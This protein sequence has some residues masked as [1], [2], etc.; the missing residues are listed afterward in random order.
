MTCPEC[1]KL[2]KTN[3]ELHRR[4]QKAESKAMNI[5]K[6]HNP[7]LAEL[8]MSCSLLKDYAGRLRRLYRSEHRLF[9]TDDP[10]FQERYE[11]Y[12]DKSKLFQQ[13]KNW[14]TGGKK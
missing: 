7:Q 10:L 11:Q 14:I 1:K 5:F 13:F 3:K 6:A 8:E 12:L 9:Q 4:L 2:R